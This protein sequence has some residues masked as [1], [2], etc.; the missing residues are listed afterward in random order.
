MRTNPNAEY[1]VAINNSFKKMENQYLTVRI[2]FLYI[3]NH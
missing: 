2:K 3:V 1:S